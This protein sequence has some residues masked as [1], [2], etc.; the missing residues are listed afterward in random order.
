MIE[1]YEEMTARIEKV[2]TFCKFVN[3]KQLILN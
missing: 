1:G 3:K 2:D